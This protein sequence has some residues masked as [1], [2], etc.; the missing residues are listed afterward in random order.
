MS[1]QKLGRLP[2]DQRH[3]F[4]DLN[5]EYYSGISSRIDSN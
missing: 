1:K 5:E 2:G 3:L 4:E